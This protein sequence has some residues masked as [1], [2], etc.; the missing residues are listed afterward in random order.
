M[1]LSRLQYKRKNQ[2][3]TKL[4]P[5]PNPKPLQCSHFTIYRWVIH[6]AG[7]LSHFRFNYL[8]CSFDTLARDIYICSS[9]YS[10][11]VLV[12]AIGDF[13][14]GCDRNEQSSDAE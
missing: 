12:F 2:M 8:H 6:R 7:I 13:S 1:T 14:E 11:Q 10:K 9:H 4:K 5:L 3:E